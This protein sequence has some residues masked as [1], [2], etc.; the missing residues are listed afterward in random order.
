M[1]F[2]EFCTNKVKPDDRKYANL[3]VILAHIYIDLKDYEVAERWAEDAVKKVELE[4]EYYP[5][6][7]KMLG[8]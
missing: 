6:A 8:D 7:L 1:P 5:V 2:A 4:S 3:Y